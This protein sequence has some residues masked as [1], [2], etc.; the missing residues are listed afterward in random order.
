MAPRL[1]W[2]DAS[3]RGGIMGQIT[4]SSKIRLSDATCI[5]LVALGT[6]SRVVAQASA[7]IGPAS[8]WEA[9]AVA[10]ARNQVVRLEVDRIPDPKLSPNMKAVVDGS[11]V[12]VADKQDADGRWLI[13][14]T[15]YHV[16]FRAK[17]FRAYA[18]NADAPFAESNEKTQLFVDR[19]R[20][21]ALV[22]IAALSDQGSKL[23]SIDRNTITHR[24]AAG[25]VGLG[26]PG[27]ALGFG[28]VRARPLDVKRID[29]Q[30]SAS[31]QS[32]ELLRRIAFAPRSGEISPIGMMFQ[33]LG[34]QATLEGMSGGLV[35]TEKG[36][37][38]G[39]IYGR[40][41]DRFNLVIPAEEVVED[42][43]QAESSQNRAKIWEPFRPTALLEP[44]LF[45]GDAAATDETIE[46]R[47]DWGTLEGLSVLV[48]D[49]PLG[50]IARF[51]E[52]EVHLPRPTADP[53]D[54]KIIVDTT[55]TIPNSEHSI[56]IWVEGVQQEEISSR[57]TTV[58]VP[59]K[60]L[61]G[62]TMVTVIKESGRINDF[63]LTKLITPSRV[64]LTF[65]LEGE[66]QFLHVVR[67]LPVM[68]QRY[69]L[70]ITIVND[71]RVPPTADPQTPKSTANARLALR[72]DYAAAILNQAPFVIDV[73][74]Q[75]PS[76][77][78]VGEQ[79]EPDAGFR[80]N[81][82]GGWDLRA[83]SSQRLGLTL[84]GSVFVRGN[85]LRY[86]GL[87]LKF[88]PDE[89]CGARPRFSVGGRFQFPYIMPGKD[90]KNRLGLAVS[91]RAT[92]TNGAG[93]MRVMVRPDV[94]LD[95]AG[96][97]RHLFT[98]F[99]SR[100]LIDNDQPH[101]IPDEKI[102]PFL[103]RLGFTTP[104]GWKAEMRRGIF[105][106]DPNTRNDW[107][108]LTFRLDPDPKADGEKLKPPPVEGELLTPPENAP[109]RVLAVDAWGAPSTILQRF[110]AMAKAARPIPKRLETL[111]AE[112][113]SLALDVPADDANRFKG[114]DAR[115]GELYLLRDGAKS[116]ADRIQ[117]ALT[118]S[119]SNASA[120][121]LS[122]DLSTERMM[123]FVRSALNRPHLKI[124]ASTSTLHVQ[125]RVDTS[126]PEIALTA[127]PAPAA[128]TTPAN[129]DLDLGNQVRV[130]GAS[131]K[132][133]S[134]TAAWARDRDSLVAKVAADLALDELKIAGGV[135]SKP[136]GEIQCEF[137][138]DK[139]GTGSARFQLNV[140][141]FK[142]GGSAVPAKADVTIP[143]TIDKNLIVDFDT[144]L[145]EP[146]L[147]K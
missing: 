125:A 101:R 20:E 57:R 19:S 137:E 17:G 46:D 93:R 42:C 47:R 84:N 71:P 105:V 53:P 27:L 133:K 83:I 94:P 103:E 82:D 120:L 85:M 64:D 73:P 88:V 39:L 86:D 134:A 130:R 95:L 49:D 109:L 75:E 124:T 72:L 102:T 56:K 50:S 87:E 2:N 28:A 116:V 126:P 70:F 32:L 5:T 143:F 11:A 113:V 45:N 138:P 61:P 14:A 6:G 26:P 23:R 18:A 136:S 135:I 108:I 58:T 100:Y 68:I 122:M 144:S 12:I 90:D 76:P 15:A 67:S 13:L 25:S 79:H 8:G 40:R 145:L 34:D 24:I 91:A 35:V 51:Q 36:Q 4:R 78:H 115:T 96:V 104:A 127:E 142:I 66:A 69:P 97:L 65:Q 140:S 131:L 117:H 37:F 1:R 22:R 74:I 31:A 52:I 139:G 118:T 146:F 59:L 48:G 112:H 99:V 21:I 44:S 107:L 41:S 33:L 80:M 62:E 54:L 38:A 77:K 119:I 7:P 129:E 128:F 114:I 63:E 123:D 29:F 106:T 43:E 10:V 111:R 55:A 9:K 110:A 132:I 16:L 141:G 81:E 89:N 92:A 60:K 147:S 30:G 3:D 121:T 98:A